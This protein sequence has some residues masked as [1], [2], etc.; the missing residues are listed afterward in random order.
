MADKQSLSF[1]AAGL[2]LGSLLTT[3]AFSLILRPDPGSIAGRGA[4]ARAKHPVAP[5]ELTFAHALDQA[6][7]VHAAIVHMAERLAQLSAGRV[8]LKIFPNGQLGSE[9]DSI[10]QVQRG[11][12]AMAKTSAA[13]LEGFLPE[14]ALF[15]MPY[16]FRDEAHYW[17]VLEGPIGERLLAAGHRVGL[18]GLCYYDSGSR[19]FY[20]VGSA[21][22]RPEDLEGLK[23]R[24]MHS[25]SSMDMVSQLGG[26]PTPVPWG[27]LYAALQQGMV[28][29]AENNPPSLLSSRHFEVTKFYSLDEHT[30]IPDV[31]I[32]SYPLWR[33]LGAEVQAWLAQAAADSVVF[34][35]KLWKQKTEES[36]RALEAGGVRVVRPD[37]EPFRARVRPLYDNPASEQLRELIVEVQATP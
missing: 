34:Q 26:A 36:L 3:S 30:R 32:F 19:S 31:V 2:L 16:L 11:A 8:Q 20:T 13:T 12:L 4:G 7:P 10:E 22:E 21:V 9:T 37:K 29:G 35:R 15:G 25:K 1:L 18:H 14:M 6:H 17:R 28:D 5:L 24:V 27:E 33:G 23:I